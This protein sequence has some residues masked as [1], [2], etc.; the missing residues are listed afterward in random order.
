MLCSLLVLILA[1]TKTYNKYESVINVGCSELS[2]L[3]DFK[4]TFCSL[5][6]RPNQQCRMNM[7][8]SVGTCV[9]FYFLIMQSGDIE[10][11]CCPTKYPCGICNN[12]NVDWNAKSIQ[13]DSCYIWFHAKCGNIGPESFKIL[14]KTEVKWICKYC[15]IPYHSSYHCIDLDELR[16]E[17][18]YQTISSDN[19]SVMLNEPTDNIR[20]TTT[21]II[22]N[23]K[24]V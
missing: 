18:I 19:T 14:N 16:S 4:L 12:K 9:M 24:T 1:V 10:L 21:P 20:L 11:N 3:S 23:T 8:N 22:F 2:S 5:I 7:K 17:N 6:S 13:C 15:S